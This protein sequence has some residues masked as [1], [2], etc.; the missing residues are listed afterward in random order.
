M[1]E[2]HPS[3]KQPATTER[4]HE[5]G[6]KISGS[7][8]PQ[9]PNVSPSVSEPWKL[10]FET[11][12]DFEFAEILLESRLDLKRGD[13]LIKLIK[14]CIEGTG[15]FTISNFVQLQSN[16]KKA[17]EMLMPVCLDLLLSMALFNHV[18]Y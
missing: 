17:S 6:V 9:S 3:S 16:W 2:Y 11:R 7:A 12:Q 14:T 13:A 1:T 18:K 5:Y 15:T 10:F 4:F 8:V